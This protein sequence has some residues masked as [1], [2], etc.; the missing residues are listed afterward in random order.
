MTYT[1]KQVVTCL[2]IVYLVIATALGGYAS[3]RANN[4]SV[5]ISNTLTAFTTALPIISGLLLEAGYDLTRVKERRQHMS[6][7]EI[8][9]PPL[10]IVANTIIF[11]YSTVVITL[12]GTHAAPPSGLNCSLHERWQKLFHNK[13]RD[14]IKTI[15]DAFNCCGFANSHDMA[16]PFPDKTHSIH[17]CETT[18]NRNRGCSDAWKAEEQQTAGLLIVVVGL[19][20][21]WQFAII[22]IPTHKES[23][24]HKLAPDRISRMIADE[25]HG[26]TA[27]R[28]AID[29]VPGYN[30]YSDRIEEDEEE[31][32][33]N[34]RTGRIEEG[35]RELNNALPGNVLGGQETGVEN[36]WARN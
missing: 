10:V 35:N 20:F 12:L 2:S 14:A 23:W 25:R 33:E 30:R 18:F 27:P 7:G 11:I 21:I 34:T 24:L 1:R 3:S 15:Q 26:D 17:A 5:P 28:S 13:D 6:R 9:R 8:Q 32:V 29:Y 31:H 36:E 22:A 16:W 19:V 4:R